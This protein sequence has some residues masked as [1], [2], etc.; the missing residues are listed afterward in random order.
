MRSF[1]LICLCLVLLPWELGAAIPQLS[2]SERQG[3]RMRLQDLLNEEELLIENQRA[4]IADLRRQERDFRLLQVFDRIPFEPRIPS[5]KKEIARIAAHHGVHIQSF[6]ATPKKTAAQPLP[7]RIHSNQQLPHLST[8]QLVQRIEFQLIARGTRPAIRNWLDSWPAD[9]LRYVETAQAPRPLGEGLWKIEGVAFRFRPV[10]MPGIEPRDPR[11]LLPPWV[12]QNKKL[13]S[14]KEPYLQGMVERIRKLAPEAGP[15][16]RHRTLFALNAARMSF[17][18]SL[19]HRRPVSEL[20][21]PH[22]R[23]N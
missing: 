10:K 11:E 5:L 15:L 16:Y 23:V 20:P 22:E 4:D 9:H 14:A 21:H 1:L 8:K 12:R 7:R 3:L 17:F 19:L 13:F 6:S 2:P 18:M